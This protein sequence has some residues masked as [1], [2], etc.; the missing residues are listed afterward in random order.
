MTRT[1]DSGV[2]KVTLGTWT[3]LIGW[4]APRRSGSL[5]E[6]E[7]NAAKAM[8]AEESEFIFIHSMTK[9]F[10]ILMLLLK[11][12]FHEFYFSFDHVTEY[13]INLITLLNDYILQRRTEVSPRRLL[14]RLR[15]ARSAL[16]LVLVPRAR[17]P[18]RGKLRRCA[19]RLRLLP[20]QP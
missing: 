11:D 8:E 9:F 5:T 12:Y 10:T 2:D 16:L 7:R 13:L 15:G 6:S 20:A 18:S 3:L 1:T 4:V 14:L 17:P 19:S